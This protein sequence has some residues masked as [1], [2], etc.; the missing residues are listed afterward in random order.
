MAHDMGTLA[1]GRRKRLRL[2][3]A[4][5]KTAAIAKGYQRILRSD[6]SLSAELD[7]LTLLLKMKHCMA[8][9][10][11]IRKSLGWLYCDRSGFISI[12]WWRF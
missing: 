9:I 10:W 6:R 8:F 5:G 1:F 4:G 3:S 2:L 7:V 12:V 11:L